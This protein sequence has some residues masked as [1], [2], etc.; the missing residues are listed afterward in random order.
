[1]RFPAMVW[2]LILLPLFTYGQNIKLH[3]GNLLVDEKLYAVYEFDGVKKSNL[4][5]GSVEVAPENNPE[6]EGTD[7]YNV[8]FSVPVTSEQYIF[9][10]A[11]VLASPA[12]IYLQYYY[13]IKFPLINKELNITYHPFLIEYLARDIAKY[14]VFNDGHWNED[15]ALKLYNAW[16]T[17][18]SVIDNK[19][20]AAGKSINYNYS[21]LEAEPDNNTIECYVKENSIYIADRLFATYRLSKKIKGIGMPGTLKSDY[22]FE[23]ED[24]NGREIAL[25]RVP[26]LRSAIYL[27]PVADK[28]Y[29][30]I[31][32]P[33]RNEQKLIA[34]AAKVLSIRDATK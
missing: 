28:D 7:F 3:N 27:Q 29:I 13:N 11:K 4:P 33:E 2:C 21:E 16:A 32:T 31:I 17:K 34:I 12:N 20:L 25:L 8:R 18:I 15:G 24:T 5:V 1:M 23:I 9:A 6:V 14:D 30:E 10:T 19:N 26:I 22:L